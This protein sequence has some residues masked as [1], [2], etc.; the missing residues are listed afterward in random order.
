MTRTPDDERLLDHQYDEIQEYDNPLP[1]W[2][3]YLFWATILYALLYWIDIPG[4]GTGKGRIA[5]YEHDMAEARAK[6]GSALAPVQMSESEL[7]AL[8]AIRGEVEEG[9]KTF[10]LNCMPCH[11]ADGGGMIGPNLTDRYWIHGGKPLEVL[12]TVSQGV[13]QKGMPAWGQVMKPDQVASVTAYVL[14]LGRTHPKNP[15]GPEGLDADSLSA[16]G[17]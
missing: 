1:R 4:I 10:D 8:V 6:Y 7:L 9:K 5:D 17:R 12:T 14:T 13:P 2:W 16:V 3:V 11:R 15:K